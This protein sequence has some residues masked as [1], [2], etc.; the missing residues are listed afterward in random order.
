[1]RTMENDP[2]AVE[3]LNSMRLNLF[4][5]IAVAEVWKHRNRSVPAAFPRERLSQAARP[6]PRDH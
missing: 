6:V 3:T 1:M 4:W 5:M 2:D